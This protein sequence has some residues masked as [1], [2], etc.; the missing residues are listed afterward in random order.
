MSAMQ[1][2]AGTSGTSPI[3]QCP[4]SAKGDVASRRAPYEPD[5][6]DP[7]RSPSIFVVVDGRPGN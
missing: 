5:V 1:R 7:I 6:A 3:T 4:L 2:K